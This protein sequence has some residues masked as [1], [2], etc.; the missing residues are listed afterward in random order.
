MNLKRKT[1][2]VTE[3]SFKIL[4]RKI[5]KALPSWPY[6][7]SNEARMS[8]YFFPQKAASKTDKEELK[9]TSMEEEEKH[10]HDA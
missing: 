4:P 7:M 6:I 2:V 1:N 3:I 8:F 10:L 9:D 5:K